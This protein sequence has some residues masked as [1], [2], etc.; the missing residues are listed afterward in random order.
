MDVI[1]QVHICGNCLSTFVPRRECLNDVLKCIAEVEDE[2]V[3]LVWMDAIEAGQSLDGI[4]TGE[5]FVNIH[6]VKERLVEPGLELFG[7]D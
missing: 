7:D 6:R 3:A 4:E 2:R 5:R 1:E